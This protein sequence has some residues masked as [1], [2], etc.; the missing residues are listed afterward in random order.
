LRLDPLPKAVVIDTNLW[1]NGILDVG[2]L[3][4]IAEQVAKVGVQ[5]WIRTQVV[6]EWASRAHEDIKIIEPPWK[7]LRRAAIVQ[8]PLEFPADVHAIVEGLTKRIEAIPNVTVLPMGGAAAVAGMRDQI[9]GTG[10][11]TRKNGVK[12]GAVDS[13]FVRGALNK[14][15]NDPTRVVFISG[16]AGD[17][18]AVAKEMGIGPLIIRDENN[19][20]GALFFSMSAPKEVQQYI[21]GEFLG[22]VTIAPPS[23][24]PHSQMDHPYFNEPWFGISDIEITDA[25]LSDLLPFDVTELQLEAG[26]YRLVG[27]RFM[28]IFESGEGDPYSGSVDFDAVLI[29]PVSASGYELDADGEVVMRGG[30]LGEVVITAPFSASVANNQVSFSPTGT[31]GAQG[32]ETRFSGGSDALEWLGEFVLSLA[33]VETVD[34][35]G[36]IDDDLTL[37]G[38]NGRKVPVERSGDFDE[39][40]VSFDLETDVVEIGCRYDPGA[41]VWAGKDSFD[42]FPP[43]YVV[44]VNGESE[45]GPGP[46]AAIAAVWV[47]LVEPL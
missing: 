47:H 7:R 6:L 26:Q 9:L 41:R 31:A 12:T 39:W 32:P 13:S 10:L 11:G 20:A 4:K 1:G 8:Q 46:Y 3:K 15:G 23:P 21:A 28:D 45:T 16:N 30:M 29:G 35:T 27:L 33:G 36:W 38:A 14:V 19:I 42:M 37:E 34:D 18:K 25:G 43:Y 2:R 40:T 17:L 44:G 5:V 22:L 24:D